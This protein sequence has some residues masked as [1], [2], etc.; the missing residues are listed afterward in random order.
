MVTEWKTGLYAIRSGS[1]PFRWKTERVHLTSD[2]RWKRSDPRRAHDRPTYPAQLRPIDRVA[3]LSNG[4][5]AQGKY[6]VIHLGAGEGVEARRLP[7]LRGYG[8]KPEP[9][10]DATGISVA[11]NLPQCRCL[12]QPEHPGS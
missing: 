1:E 8:G 5:Q 11:S 10:P 7:T 9:E 6:T 4:L 3:S 12:I 2:K